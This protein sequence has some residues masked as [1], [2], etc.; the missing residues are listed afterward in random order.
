MNCT[1]P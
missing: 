1:S